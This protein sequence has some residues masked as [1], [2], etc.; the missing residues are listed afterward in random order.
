MVGL[1]I[2]TSAQLNC[3]AMSNHSKPN[4]DELRP[5]RILQVGMHFRPTK[6]LLT[7]VKL[8]LFTHLAEGPLTGREIQEKLNLHPRALYDFLDALVALEFLEREGL[9]ETAVYRNTPE[10]DRFLDKNKP[11]YIGG[12]L[13]MANNRLY[14]YWDRLEEALK[15]GQPQNEI[16]DGGDSL[17]DV[18]YSEPDRLRE[19][20]GAMGNAQSA[21]F[22]AFA[23]QMDFS[24]YSTLCDVGGASGALSIQVAKHNPH[25]QCTSAD[26]PA[27]EPIAR[28][29]IAKHH[30]QDRI[31][32]ISLDFFNED[33]PKADVIT[34]GNILHD[35]GLEDKMMLIR[36][37][38]DAIPRG[39]AFVVIEN[40][41][42][43]ERKSNVYGLLM[44]LNMLIETPEGFDYTSKDFTAW[45]Q[46]IGFSEV[47]K[48]RLIGST[49]AL[50]AI[51]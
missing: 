49:S 4:Q 9:L 22:I 30:L 44:S 48:I 8:E 3:H 12:I 23:Q 27:V 29:N 15:T 13:E 16:R 40:I 36:K 26:L 46:E 34:M 41:I 39:G 7:A 43:D 47:S 11:T 45:A 31:K 19:F 42:D 20:I 51:K 33:L 28:E 38:Y 2:F 37:A 10:T 18:L 50:I 6:T 21:S 5:K 25:M 14:K 32:V 24:N 1:D 17:F 35:W